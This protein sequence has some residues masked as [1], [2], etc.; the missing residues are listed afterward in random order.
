[1]LSARRA[2]RRR[3]ATVFRAVLRSAHLL[4][5]RHRKSKDMR[6]GTSIVQFL[7]QISVA[8]F[9]LV[10]NFIDLL[11]QLLAIIA[12]RTRRSKS[13]SLR[14]AARRR[15]DCRLLSSLRLIPITTS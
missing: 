6:L 9:F 14:V 12:N 8:L 13:L 1:M 5:H 10:Q 15:L 7:L 3:R 11:L 4:R 2:N